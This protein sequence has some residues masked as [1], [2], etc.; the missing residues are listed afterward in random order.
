MK[1][2][3]LAAGIGSRLGNPFPKPLTVLDNGSS[4]MQQQ[5]SHLLNHLSIHD[6]IVVVGF[7]MELIVEEFPD[8]TYVYNERFDS[9]NTSKSLLKGLS[10]VRGEDAVFLNGDVV[11]DPRVLS[12]VLASPTSAMAVNTA[13]VA[14]EE[15]KYLTAADGSIS[16]VSKVV[17][18]GLGE[19]VGVN[20]IKAADLDLV[21]EKLE[22]VDDN[23]YFE[24]GLELAI[25]EG[26][27]LYPVDISDLDCIE[28][29]FAEDL[30]R[31]NE[32]VRE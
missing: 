18:G 13:R 2:V 21:R 14:E 7:K 32:F 19:A 28:V 23:D 22:V 12:R 29:D 11:F 9:T 31:A 3:I 1:A 8:L 17:E 24:R 10:R 26:L 4:I 25:A 16:A 20:F 5:V 27:R 30:A 15:V 6:I